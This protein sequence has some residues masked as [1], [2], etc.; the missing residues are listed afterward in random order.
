MFEMNQTTNE[1]IYQSQWHKANSLTNLSRRTSRADQNKHAQSE[2][3]GTNT[4]P[5]FQG[6]DTILFL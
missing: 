6:V 4:T 5:V 3:P 2:V 1:L